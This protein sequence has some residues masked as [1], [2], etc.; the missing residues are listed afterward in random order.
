MA[1]LKILYIVTQGE[2]GGA[3]RY[4]FD[5]ATSF[6]DEFDVTIAIGEQEGR[7]D[8]QQK[9]QIT[10]YKL[11][12]IQLRHLVRKISPFHDILAIFELAKLYKT[13]KPDIIHL[14]SSKAGILGSFAKSLFTHHSSLIYTAHGWV[15]NEPLNRAKKALYQW[16]ERF[17][18]RWKNK[19]IVLSDFD[20][21]S[22][23]KI[24]I[25]K[26]KIIKIPL[27]IETPTFLDKKEA[28][29][30]IL[31]I[32]N[33][34]DSS[35]SFHFGRND[36]VIVTIANLYSTKGLDTLI[37]AIRLLADRERDSSTSFHFGRNDSDIKFV[38][39]GEGP[40]R[41]NLEN[42]IKKNQLKNTVFLTGTI[43]NASQYLKA[44]DLFVLPSRKEGLPYTILE[45]IAAGLPI[46][47]TDVGG[48]KELVADAIT[49]NDPKI[50]AEKIIQTI[51]NPVCT[52]KNIPQLREMFEKTKANY[53]SCLLQ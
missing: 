48:V 43:D 53:L 28:R 11:Q 17:T 4:V 10:N 46:V 36:T 44:F 20:R 9:L 19:I 23:E 38:I 45:A 39:I 31:D 49:P 6:A 50:L 24:G 42:L 41:K 1:K 12:I 34:R 40:E 22:G 30:K 21:H 3:Q 15:F 35:T 14:N 26:E 7:R 25:E 18:A 32:L 2:C 51:K 52:Q 8:L 27:G 16:L 29:E 47:A 5:L 33:K 37:E 13:L